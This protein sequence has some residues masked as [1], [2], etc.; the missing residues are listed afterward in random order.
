MHFTCHLI[1][2]QISFARKLLSAFQT[3]WLFCESD[4]F[5][6]VAPNVAFGIFGAS[7]SALVVAQESM[8][9][10]HILEALPSVA[11]FNW[12]NVFIFEL[13]N[14]RSPESVREDIVNK[15]WRPLPSGRM[16]SEQTRKLMLFAIPGVLITNLALGVWKETALLLVLTWLYNDL[17]GGDELIRDVII[18][19]AFGCYNHGSLRL[20]AGLRTEISYYGYSWIAC[21]S[22]VIL[23]TMQ[24]QD[25]KDQQGDRLRGRR[26]IPLAFGETFSRYSIAVAVLGWSCAMFWQFPML[27]AL[28]PV[29]LGCYICY[30]VLYLRATKADSQTWK[31]WCLWTISLYALPMMSHRGSLVRG[32]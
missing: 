24:V 14:Q 19:L 13:A 6:F 23:T 27:C 22:L 25:L 4:V 16:D 26:T 2:A 17:K 7:S 28:L 10:V 3:L 29:I 18:S 21:I 1:G 30:R 9:M 31:W 12:S 11:L 20:A 8:S 15:P 32:H 5:T